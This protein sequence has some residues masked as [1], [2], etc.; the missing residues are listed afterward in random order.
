MPTD[1]EFATGVTYAGKKLVG[2]T[3]E[4]DG[5]GIEIDAK[6]PADTRFAYDFAPEWSGPNGTERVVNIIATP[7]VRVHSY[8]RPY[9]DPSVTYGRRPVADVI[10]VQNPG[11]VPEHGQR[12]EPRAFL[13]MVPYIDP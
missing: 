12:F 1:N 3:V 11:W 10:Y 4:L 6:A 5:K 8:A 7:G 13:A 2:V 9:G